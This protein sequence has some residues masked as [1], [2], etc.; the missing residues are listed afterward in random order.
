MKDDAYRKVY[1]DLL[2]LLL[3]KDRAVRTEVVCSFAWKKD[4]ACANAMF[5]L[6]RDDS[7]DEI[8]HSRIVQAMHDLTGTYFEYHIGSDGWR[9]TTENNKMA[10]ERFKKWIENH[11]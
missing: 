3:D 7:M 8:S 9:P 4:A 11:K 10:I 2:T 6:L 1:S 5:D